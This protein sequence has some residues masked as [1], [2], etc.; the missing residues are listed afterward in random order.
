MLC[1]PVIPMGL[2]KESAHVDLDDQ[3]YERLSKWTISR[4]PTPATTNVTESLG[5]KLLQRL[6]SSLIS[7]EGVS[8]AE[9]RNELRELRRKVGFS[10]DVL[11]ELGGYTDRV[12]VGANVS[13]ISR[14]KPKALARHIQLDPHPFDCMGIAVPMTEDEVRAVCSDILP[15]LQSILGVRVSLSL[16]LVLEYLPRFSITCSS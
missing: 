4:F 5:I 12:S 16:W 15:Q 2:T 3:A 1:M 10:L 7:V 9:H 13:P 8:T 14:K 6:S 11:K